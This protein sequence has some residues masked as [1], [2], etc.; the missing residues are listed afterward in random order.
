MHEHTVIGY[1]GW[2]L[3][4][5]QMNYDIHELAKIVAAKLRGVTD[6]G[7]RTV[8]NATPDDLGRNVELDR[9]ISNETGINIIC[10]TGKYMDAGAMSSLIASRRVS[11]DMADRL[12]DT[13]MGEIDGW[14]SWFWRPGRCY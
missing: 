9:I 3:E 7:V 6:Y 10:S 8:V 11:M 12:Y 14:H 13:F 1:T 5:C 4:A 2:D